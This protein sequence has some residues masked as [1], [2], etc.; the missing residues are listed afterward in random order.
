MQQGKGPS[1]DRKG[2]DMSTTT[3]TMRDGF[4]TT[5]GE[6]EEWLTQ[7]DGEMVRAEQAPMTDAERAEQ[8]KFSG[9]RNDA[10]HTLYVDRSLAPGEKQSRH[11]R[12]SCGKYLGFNPD[13]LGA[14]FYRAHRKSA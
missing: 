11:F 3:H 7:T 13:Y 14:R 2:H 1:A 4:C 5:C 9:V 10:A 8:F 12:C 6:T